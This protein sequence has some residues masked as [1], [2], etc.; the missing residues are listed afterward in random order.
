MGA[1]RGACGRPAGRDPAAEL[2]DHAAEKAVRAALV[3][4]R[5]FAGYFTVLAVLAA[6]T[7]LLVTGVPRIAERLADDG[8]HE[9]IRDRSG[10]ARDI[11]YRYSPAADNED[12]PGAADLGPLLDNLLTRM[13]PAVRAVIAERWYA[14]ETP[15]S[16]ATGP[17]LQSPGP[18]LDLILRTT[19]GAQDAVT[20]TTGRWPTASSEVVLAAPVAAGLHLR[21]GS[22]LDLA[23]PQSGARP[24][25]VT[26]VGLFTPKDPAD[27]IWDPLPPALKVTPP[28]GQKNPDPVTAVALTSATAVAERRAAGWALSYTWR[29][30][31]DPDR[32]TADRAAAVLDGI[33]RLDR[34]RPGGTEFAQGLDAPLQDFLAARD[35]A[36]AVLFVVLAAVLATLA[37]LVVLTARLLARRRDREFRLLRARG[38][39]PSAVARRAAAE[40][41]LVVLPAAVAGW[42]AAG[43]GAGAWTVAPAALLIAAAVPL[44][45]PA[46]PGRAYRRTAEAAILVLAAAGT[47]LL[48][49]RGL[50]T[51]GTV[52]PLL[53]GVPV[54]L[55]VSV[56]G[57]VLRGYPWL[58]R[59]ARR[60]AARA[61]GAIAFLGVAMARRA[62]TGPLI[63]VVL[64]VAGAAFC[65]GVAAGVRDGRDRATALAVPADALL[66]ADRLAADTATALAAV[67]GVEAVTPLTAQSEQDILRPGGGAVERTYVLVLDGPGFARAA[68]ANFTLPADLT[69]A[70]RT[71]GRVPALVSPAV[72]DDLPGAGVVAV[73]NNSYPFRIAG[74]A[75][76]FPTVPAGVRRFVVLP[77]QAL[78]RPLTPTGF[79]IAG[80]GADPATL[81]RVGDAGRRRWYSTGLVVSRP[82]DVAPV[83]TTRTGFRIALDRGGANSLLWFG[84]AGGVLGGAL[85]ALAAVVFAVLADAP[86]RGRV[87]A[88]LRTM[89]LSR[90]QR[91][92]IL[93][94]EL[95]PPVGLAVLTGTA[96]GMLLPILVGP[97]L[98]L[99]A[100][101]GGVAVRL[102]ADAR[103]AAGVIVFGMLALALAMVAGAA[104][105]RRLSRERHLLEED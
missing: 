72:A 63:V 12:Q 43:A 53:V 87:L 56:G 77:A 94:V 38:A 86:A 67:P 30:R 58:L 18:P 57:L 69:D 6:L 9:Q 11:V 20:L 74:V 1:D 26:V 102:T 99:S 92:R 17:D 59:G 7:A 4:V 42:A 39:A 16:R 96:V 45:V 34:T 29:Y 65:A 2:D 47:Y 25:A 28:S 81:Q 21:T 50:P 36:R 93:I 48:R 8:L 41:L 40:S 52:D 89:G 70:G 64:A 98:R 3:R 44:A 83:L 51:A 5:A 14:A 104:A 90:R 100:F 101:T 27:G 35:A 76:S 54:L 79:L 60:A 78:P 23:A 31:A 19:G 75:E 33:R 32:L 66:T 15:V 61:R 82:P 84:V 49:R 46:G 88:R 22:R 97:V 37:G 105:D 103:L 85:L 55:T 13:P 62:P 95:A 71:G 73:Q 24:T 68:H 10:P 91:H 80:A